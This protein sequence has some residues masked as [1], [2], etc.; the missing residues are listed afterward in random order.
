MFY[1]EHYGKVLI[2]GNWNA[3]T[4]NRYDNRL[5]VINS[6]IDFY[7]YTPDIYHTRALVDEVFNSRGNRMLDFRKSASLCITNGRIGNTGS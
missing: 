3:R 4:G 7:S 1:C 2:A 6:A 5:D